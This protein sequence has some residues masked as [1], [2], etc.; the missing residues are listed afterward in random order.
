M[1]WRVGME[2]KKT[3]CI[4]T[5]DGFY[6]AIDRINMYK[7]RWKLNYIPDTCELLC[8]IGQDVYTIKTA[9]NPEELQAILDKYITTD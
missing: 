7:I 5:E 9:H 8:W 2:N 4:K 3:R 6:L 1:K